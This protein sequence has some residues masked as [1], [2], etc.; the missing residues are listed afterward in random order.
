MTAGRHGADAE[1]RSLLLHMRRAELT[2]S[3]KELLR[4][5][6]VAAAP[7]DAAYLY[8]TTE[9]ANV[10]NNKCLV[11]LDQ[12]LVVLVAEDDYKLLSDYH[13]KQLLADYTKAEYEMK[14]CVGAVDLL[15]CNAYF[16]SHGL[17]A[18]ARGVVIGFYT[19]ADKRGKS[20]SLPTVEFSLPTAARR[21]LFIKREVFCVTSLSSR[22]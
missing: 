18:G 17:S 16:H 19:L 12:P 5:R 3:K 10:R 15:A 11:S 13:G 22:D 7:G 20:E 6:V 9:A 2:R 8:S 14:L 1:F 21:R 4:S